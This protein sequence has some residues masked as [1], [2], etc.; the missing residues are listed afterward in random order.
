MWPII[1]GEIKSD[2][3]MHPK[4]DMDSII[5]CYDHINAEDKAHTLPKINLIPLD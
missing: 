3:A 1:L 4:W 5:V 2:N